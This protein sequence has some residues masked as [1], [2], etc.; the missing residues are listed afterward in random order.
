MAATAPSAVVKRTKAHACTTAA[1]AAAANAGVREG[2][3]EEAD[4]ERHGE[5]RAEGRN[6][7]GEQDNAL[8]RSYTGEGMRHAVGAKAEGRC[9]SGKR[10]NKASR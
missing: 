5:R 2:A 8:G 1:V 9:W 10:D 3:Q 7:I 4:A 6:A